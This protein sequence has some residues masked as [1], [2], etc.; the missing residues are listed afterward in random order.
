[1]DYQT[2]IWLV[3]F[4]SLLFYILSYHSIYNFFKSSPAVII[5]CVNAKVVTA[6]C[7]CMQISFEI[8]DK[9]CDHKLKIFFS[10]YQAT[11]IK[12]VPKNQKDFNINELTSF[13]RG[14]RTYRWANLLHSEFTESLILSLIKKFEY[15]KQIVSHILA[16]RKKF[17]FQ[18]VVKIQHLQK[19]SGF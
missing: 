10:Y 13:K 2:P 9:R 7:S 1:M 16:N 4:Q 15:Y 14:K 5:R 11:Q 17:K 6:L 19:L 3:S 12:V 18:T 8:L